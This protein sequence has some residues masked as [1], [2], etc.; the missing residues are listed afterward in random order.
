MF[1]I[2]VGIVTF[3]E[4]CHFPGVLNKEQRRS[5]AHLVQVVIQHYTFIINNVITFCMSCTAV[6][7][8]HWQRQTPSNSQTLST[9]H[10][11]DCCQDNII[12]HNTLCTMY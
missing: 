7:R 11:E 6:G 8:L 5:H 1:T 2:Q 12:L 4:L 3:M 9:P 10:Q